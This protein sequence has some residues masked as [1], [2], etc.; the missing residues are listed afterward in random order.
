MNLSLP[1]SNTSYSSAESKE[2]INYRLF[3]Q[4]MWAPVHYG[5]RCTINRLSANSANPLN[6]QSA[7]INFTFPFRI[8]CF[9]DYT[10]QVTRCVVTAEERCS[11]RQSNL[12]TMLL[13]TFHTISYKTKRKIIT[14]NW[15]NKG[16]YTSY[17]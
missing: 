2:Q 3:R 7:L 9:I 13:I 14:N 5:G 1:C 6:R 11:D 16:C 17:W 15:Y 8:N 4:Y 10:R 12:M